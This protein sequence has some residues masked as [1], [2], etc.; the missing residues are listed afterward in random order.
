MTKITFRIQKAL[1]GG[2]KGTF[3]NR[4]NG[5]IGSDGQG[6]GFRGGKRL[7]RFNP[8][9]RRKKKIVGGEKE[10]L[11][12]KIGEGESRPGPMSKE[13]QRGKSIQQGGE[14]RRISWPRVSG[15]ETGGNRGSF[16][17]RDH[18]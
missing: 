12:K 15:K 4:A 10:V 9:A 8:S 13:G 7:R 17:K 3:S 16:R 18:S 14:R 2:G 6:G 5:K 1:R 11:E